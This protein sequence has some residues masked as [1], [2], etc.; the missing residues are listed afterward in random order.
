M[1]KN[2]ILHYKFDDKIENIN[3]NSWFKFKILKY[4]IKMIE[5][6]ISHLIE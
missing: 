6:V 5:I 2:Y 1:I 4:K 3:N